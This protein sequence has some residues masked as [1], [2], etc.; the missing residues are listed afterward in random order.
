MGISNVQAPTVGGAASPSRTTSVIPPLQRLPHEGPPTALKLLTIN[1][2]CRP[3][4]LHKCIYP[5][6][7]LNVPRQRPNQLFLGSCKGGGAHCN[8]SLLENNAVTADSDRQGLRGSI[9]GQG[10]YTVPSP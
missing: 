4:R 5:F 9:F 8:Q 3:I 6:L 10:I 7:S 2:V 1:E